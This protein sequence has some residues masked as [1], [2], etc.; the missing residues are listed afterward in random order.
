MTSSSGFNQN[1]RSTIIW[2]CDRQDVGIDDYLRPSELTGWMDSEDQ[3]KNSFTFKFKKKFCLP[4][5]NTFT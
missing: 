4:I 2:M 3:A 1:Q 5:I